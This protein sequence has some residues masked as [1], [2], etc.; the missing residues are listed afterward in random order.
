MKDKLY[1]RYINNSQD[2]VSITYINSDIVGIDKVVDVYKLLNKVTN[3]SWT[4]SVDFIDSNPEK[5]IWN[6]SVIL[7]ING[8]C[9]TGV[10]TSD[11]F[12]GAVNNA[13]ITACKAMFYTYGEE[14]S[15]EEPK[16]SKESVDTESNNN[17]SEVNKDEYLSFDEID[18][19]DDSNNSIIENTGTQ[20]E[21]EDDDDT[22]IEGSSITN[23]QIRFMNEFK[24]YNNIDT[25]EK[26]DY[27]V[28]TWAT[29][30]VIDNIMTKKEL[31]K[32]GYDMLENF[33]CWIKKMQPVLDNGVKS[34]IE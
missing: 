30:N 19:A 16:D 3:N 27:Y 20:D 21:Y 18:K 24:E 1:E 22:P 6:V 14:V 33:I 9:M 5:T 28:K 32:A 25:D 34:P 17:E 8:R 12:D 26:F 4:Y 23:R 15:C 10:G 2:N 31:V 7:F 11:C 13:L 29:N